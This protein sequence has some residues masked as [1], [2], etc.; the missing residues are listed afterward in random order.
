[1]SLSLQNNNPTTVTMVAS[2]RH[3]LQQIQWTA[4]HVHWDTEQSDTGLHFSHTSQDDSC[5]QSLFC[6]SLVK[7]F[8]FFLYPHTTPVFFETSS[9][10]PT[11]HLLQN[12]TL[13]DKMPKFKDKSSDE[14]PSFKNLLLW[15]V[16][17]IHADPMLM[18]NV[19]LH[20]CTHVFSLHTFL[21]PLL[22]CGLLPWYF[23]SLWSQP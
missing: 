22:A 1:M 12:F 14:A 11:F 9:L 13:K 3:R 15:M 19:S 21:T 23:F 7:F 17:L 18:L 2:D 4:I 20:F 8:S 6:N 10:I 5:G 16:R